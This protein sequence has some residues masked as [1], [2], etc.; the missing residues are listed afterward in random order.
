MAT[1]PRVFLEISHSTTPIG[2]LVIELFG[3]KTPRACEN[4]RQLC[5]GENGE[6]LSYARVPFHRVIDEFMVQGGDVE[7]QDGT[8]TKSIYGREFEDEELNWRDMDAKG[9]VACANRG[10]DS[11]G[12]QFFITLEACPHL[13]GK[14][15]IFGRVVS[16]M[17]SLET[18]AKVSVDKNDR[19]IEPV[20][21]SRCGELEKKKKPKRDSTQLHDSVAP[22]DRGRRRKSDQDKDEDEMDTIPPNK[23]REKRHRRQS[24]NVVDEGI[25]GR[26]RLR[27]QSRSSSNPIEEDEEDD[28]ESSPA[29]MHKRKRSP[30]PS[31][32]LDRR[33]EQAGEE[34]RRRS[35]PNQ[36]NEDRRRGYGDQDRYRPSPRRDD[37]RYH[38]RRRDDNRYRPSRDRYENEGRLGDDGRLGGSGDGY[39]PP[40]KFKGRGVMKYREPDRAW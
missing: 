10:R 25:R 21:V 14:H 32:H 30:S 34:R 5:T 35:L 22:D 39:D 40:V 15:T 13:N 12:S 19:P 20:L 16:G 6:G 4:F 36:Y 28:T 24:D 26:P 1:R 27:S 11:N 23:E 17:D 37:Y 33:S 7:K 3:D 9:L 8:G 38:G 31:R 18:I 2:R 29:R